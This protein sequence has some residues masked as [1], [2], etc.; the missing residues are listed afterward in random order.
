[1]RW[2]NYLCYLL[3]AVVALLWVRFLKACFGML[4][5]SRSKNTSLSLREQAMIL[6]DSLREKSLPPLVVVS[7][8][9]SLD[10]KLNSL[11]R[12][13]WVEFV[14]FTQPVKSRLH[15]F[16]TLGLYG[17]HSSVESCII[18]CTLFVIKFTP[19]PPQKSSRNYMIHQRRRRVEF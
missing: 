8:I 6:K 19:I 17:A 10:Y 4:Y 15:F 11:K 12:K 16:W 18:L 1:M 3:R 9:I 2:V 14:S 13:Y 5:E 7:L